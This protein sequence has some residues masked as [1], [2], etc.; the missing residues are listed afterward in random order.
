MAN[1]SPVIQID[2]AAPGDTPE[3]IALGASCTAQEIDEYKALF[4]E[5]RDV[6]AWSYTEMPGLD[7]TIKEHHIKTWPDAPPIRQKHRPIHL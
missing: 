2:L 1:I 3:L 5:F 4:K 6:F 7:P